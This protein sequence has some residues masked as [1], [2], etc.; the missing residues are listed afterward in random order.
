M[1]IFLLRA[2]SLIRFIKW[3][4]F[5]CVLFLLYVFGQLLQMNYLPSS[6]LLSFSPSSL[7]SSL[8]LQE[9]TRIHLPYFRNHLHQ[10]LQ[11]V[12]QLYSINTS[13][14]LSTNN[15]L[16]FTNQIF[17]NRPDKNVD[18]APEWLKDA[19]QL[20]TNFSTFEIPILWRS[21]LLLLN[22]RPIVQNPHLLH[23]SSHPFS[24]P[25]KNVILVQVHKI[26]SSYPLFGNH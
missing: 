6:S 24:E 12:L 8:L 1:R 26:N 23:F 25:F 21:L 3:L 10:Q 2:R 15:N 22:E 17:T 7:T 5:V 16:R 20:S 19:V 4:T 11:R 18:A 13:T 9:Q 14:Q